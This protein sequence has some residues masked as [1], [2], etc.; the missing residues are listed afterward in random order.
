MKLCIHDVY[1]DSYFIYGA[2]LAHNDR[3]ECILKSH[4]IEKVTR[5]LLQVYR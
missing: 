1:L 5:R 2:L 3:L 4:V